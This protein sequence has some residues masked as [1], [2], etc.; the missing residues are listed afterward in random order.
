MK[1][2]TQKLKCFFSGI[3]IYRYSNIPTEYNHIFNEY[4]TSSVEHLVAKN[5][6][7]YDRLPEYLKMENKVASAR[8]VN[9]CINDSPLYIKIILKD[10]L[11]IHDFRKAN[12]DEM[13]DI[14]TSEM[15]ELC[16]Q[17]AFYRCGKVENP[18]YHVEIDKMATNAYFDHIVF[19]ANEINYNKIPKFIRD[20]LT[21]EPSVKKFFIGYNKTINRNIKFG[22]FGFDINISLGIS[23]R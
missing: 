19:D 2:K 21:K 16:K 11:S 4:N 20:Q 8:L 1:H 14:V 6:S 5:N 15:G 10:R 18:D 17:Y 22:I 7:I 3:D 9:N 13:R 12:K 23:P